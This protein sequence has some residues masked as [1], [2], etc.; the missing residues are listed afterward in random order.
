M[1]GRGRRVRGSHLLSYLG[2]WIDGC[3]EEEGL[4]EAEISVVELVILYLWA[5]LVEVPRRW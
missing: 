3:T 2:V 4:E 1:V 5:F